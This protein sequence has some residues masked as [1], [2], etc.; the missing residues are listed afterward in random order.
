MDI[1]KTK[2]SAGQAFVLE[3][4]AFNDDMFTDTLVSQIENKQFGEIQDFDEFV[5]KSFKNGYKNLSKI[6]EKI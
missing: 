6:G 2:L 4:I 1:K 5:S 3:Q